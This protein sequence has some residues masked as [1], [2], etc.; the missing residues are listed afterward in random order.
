MIIASLL[1]G[2]TR[3]AVAT[4]AVIGETAGDLID[5]A[6]QTAG[7]GPIRS[8]QVRYGSW[9]GGEN[10]PAVAES[11]VVTR[12][13]TVPRT[14]PSVVAESQPSSAC[15][16]EIWEI[17]CH[18]GVVAANRILDDLRRLG[19]TVV[20]RSQWWTFA[21]GRY[22]ATERSEHLAEVNLPGRTDSPTLFAEAAETLIHTTSARTAAIALDQVRGAMARFI[23]DSF[24]TLA[25]DDVSES[26]IAV[27]ARA[28]EILR[29]ESLGMHLSQPWRVVLAGPPNVGKSSLIN[30]ILGYRRSI[31][32]DQPGTTRDVVH[33]Q[34][35]IG[36]W[37]VRLSDTAG[38]RG[39]AN[40]QIERAGIELAGNELAEADL[41]LWVRDATGM[42]DDAEKSS[43]SGLP[44]DPADPSATFDPSAKGPVVVDVINKIDRLGQ[45][46]RWEETLPHDRV[47][48]RHRVLTSAATGEGIETLRDRIASTLVPETPQPRHPV[49]L[50]DRQ[51]NALRELVYAADRAG[52]D[53]ALRRLL[54]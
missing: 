24:R 31:T 6:F 1:T 43:E 53:S 39:T 54:G 23:T 2:P 27:R 4:V 34:T 36:G 26:V 42:S 37:P 13:S 19:A 18:G 22:A 48:S 9:H 5:A 29:F 11:V 52:V 30:A 47:Y 21:G 28:A 46:D 25:G 49:P 15:P 35:V 41:V 50:C 45:R 14:Y 3:A 38:L 33:A 7:R 8:G 44:F 40:C 17:N 32:F 51:V 20:P 10:G 16:Y 12:R